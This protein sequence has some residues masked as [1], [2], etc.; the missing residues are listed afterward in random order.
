[1]RKTMLFLAV[2]SL[3]GSLWAADPIIGTWKLNIVKSTFSPVAL[4]LQG[5]KS[6]KETTEV[7]REE[8]DLI[9]MSDGLPNSDKWTWSR[10]GG[11]VTRKPPVGQGIVY[12]ET[13]ITPGH[14]I[15]TIL[16]DG[17]QAAIYHKVIDKDGKTMRQT[18]KGVD[19]DGKPF[20]QIQVYDKQ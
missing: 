14:W 5:Q 17:K 4:A 6:P 18:F 8:G 15:A 1:M 10:Q 2:F 16:I 11:V 19:P 13:L 7:Y 12:V 9:E 3:A 20:E